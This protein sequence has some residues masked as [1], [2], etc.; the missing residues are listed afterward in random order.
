M[1][2]IDPSA[3]EVPGSF[4]VGQAKR[5]SCHEK[6]R[7]YFLASWPFKTPISNGGEMM[8]STSVIAYGLLIVIFATPVQAAVMVPVDLSSWLIDGAGNWT[9]QSQSEPNDSV[10]QSLN[11]RPTMF[12]NN[13]NSQGTQ[14][15][16]AIEVQSSSDDDFVGLVLGYDDNDLF[17]SNP[18][19]NYV[20][21]DWKQITQEGWEAGMAISRV[22]GAIDAGGTDTSADAWLHVGNVTFLER[23]ATLGSTGWAD[24]TQYQFDVEF[25]PTNIKVFVDGVKQFDINGTFENGAFGFYNFSQESVLY[26]G[27][28]TADLPEPPSPPPGVVPEPTTFALSAFALLSLGL[29]G[30]RRRRR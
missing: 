2:P 16:G 24:N 9:L 18:T 3:G 12:F 15:S 20:L 26:A 6:N 22:T 21:V 10:F 25:L 11:S 30:R 14:L 27:I 29:S 28:T 1:C 17:G 23:A 8:K 19:T 4:F 13:M 5:R 7:N